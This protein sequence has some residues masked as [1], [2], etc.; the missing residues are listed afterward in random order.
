MGEKNVLTLLSQTRVEAHGSFS[1]QIKSACIR[2]I[3][4]V[5]SWNIFWY[6]SAKNAMTSF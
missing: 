5:K 3:W 2:R 6:G 1:E 4:D